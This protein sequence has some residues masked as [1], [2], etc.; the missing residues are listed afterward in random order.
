MR[1]PTAGLR[2]SARFAWLLTLIGAT[3]IPSVARA[4][5]QQPPPPPCHS[6]PDASRDTETVRNRKD[7]K[8]LPD[9]PAPPLD[10]APSPFD[11]PAPTLVVRE[12]GGARAAPS[13]AGSIPPH[14]PSAV[15]RR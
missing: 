11:G 10:L 4:K 13:P 9:P 1:T 3:L 14:L 2:R 7:V 15:L 5:H 6:N 8:S 12:A